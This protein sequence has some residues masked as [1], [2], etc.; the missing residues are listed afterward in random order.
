MTKSILI[1]TKTMWNVR[2]LSEDQY[3]YKNKYLTLGPILTAK[4]TKIEYS[5]KQIHECITIGL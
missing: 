1:K 4:V 3:S 2:K 5:I